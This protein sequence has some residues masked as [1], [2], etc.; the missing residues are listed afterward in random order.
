MSRMSL[1]HA[2]GLLKWN[3]SQLAREAGETHGNIRDLETGKNARPSYV[4][5]MRIVNALRRGGLT[6]ITPEEIFP[7]TERPARARKKVA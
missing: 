2:R 3:Q 6:G 4:L 7:V 5:V 1:E